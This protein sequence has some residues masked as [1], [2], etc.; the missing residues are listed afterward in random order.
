[1]IGKGSFNHEESSRSLQRFVSF[2]AVL[3]RVVP[4]RTFGSAD[5]QNS[6]PHFVTFAILRAVP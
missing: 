3:S 1:M 2:H 6:L 5:S 4:A